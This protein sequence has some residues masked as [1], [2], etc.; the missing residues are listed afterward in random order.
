MSNLEGILFYGN[1]GLEDILIQNIISY[2]DYGMLQLGGFY[3]ISKGRQDA[4]GE[5][6]SKFKPIIMSATGAPTNYTVYRGLK[7]NLIWESN[8][9]L[10]YASGSQPTRTSGIYVNNVL[11]ATGTSVSGNSYYLDHSRGQVVFTSAMPSNTIV[12]VPHGVRVV[13][14]LPADSNEYRNIESYWRNAS[15]TGTITDIGFKAYLP[16]IFVGI[17]GFKTI[18]GTEMG[19]RGKLTA[20][21]FEFTIYSN[22]SYEMRK[23]IDICYFLEDKLVPLFDINNTPKP[24]NSSGVLV[25]ASADWSGLVQNYSYGQGRFDDNARVNKFKNQLLPIYKAKVNISLEVDTYPI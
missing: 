12:Q 19:S 8:I 15:S 6:L 23:L 18:K 24:L 22:N 5:D 10:K 21:D 1:Y 13:S 3:N 25:N 2:L 9:T 4:Y 20:T 14:V 7:N 16:C 11:Y 17:N